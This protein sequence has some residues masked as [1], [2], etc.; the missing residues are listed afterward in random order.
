MVH[1]VLVTVKGITLMTDALTMWSSTDSLHQSVCLSVSLS[2]YMCVGFC[3]YIRIHTDSWDMRS[4]SF[5]PAKERGSVTMT[6]ALETNLTSNHLCIFVSSCFGV[7]FF[8]F[9]YFYI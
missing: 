5:V 7:F 4:C 1:T 9:V 3:S 6:M 2:V 8:M